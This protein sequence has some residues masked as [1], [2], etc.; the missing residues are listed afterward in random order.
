M[1]FA[2]PL[3]GFTVGILIGLTG[4]GGGSLMTPILVLVF[5]VSPSIAVGTDLLYAAVTKC[6]GVWVHSR[7]GS[8]RWDIV[9]LLAAGS[10]PSAILTVFL[11]KKLMSL[12][13]DYDR[14]ITLVLSVALILTS[15]VLV[16]KSAGHASEKSNTL[17]SITGY[18]RHHRGL[19]TVLAGVIV[20]ILVTLSS[21]GAG[22]LGAAMV[23]FLYPRLPIIAIAG[24]DL[25]YAV[26]LTAIAGM[27]HLQIGN[28][29]YALLGALL[30]GALPGTYL[31][32]HLG[33]R[34]PDRVVRPILA[35]CLFA[36]GIRF[37][38]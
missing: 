7:H 34:L 28:V 26:P 9:R 25:A 13:I 15:I 31:G 17:N 5:G 29:D 35:A 19:F 18:F 37:A 14:F 20:G 6:A 22:V 10:I 38:F 11:L 32:S 4:M 2:L 33:N 12:G 23:L 8:I 36:V 16:F 21:V 30:I 1:D 27:G 3:V 24:T